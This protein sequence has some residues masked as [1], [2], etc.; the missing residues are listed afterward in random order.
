M[1]AFVNKSVVGVEAKKLKWL[2]NKCVFSN[3]LKMFSVLDSRM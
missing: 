1:S 2:E 3:I